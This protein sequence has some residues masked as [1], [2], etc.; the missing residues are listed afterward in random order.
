MYTLYNIYLPQNI[1]FTIDIWDREIKTK[2]KGKTEKHLLLYLLL[3]T[4]FE[5]DNMEESKENKSMAKNVSEN[6]AEENYL[7]NRK[8]T[9]RDAFQDL[10]ASF[11][12]SL[13]FHWFMPDTERS[14]T[15]HSFSKICLKNTNPL[16]YIF[17]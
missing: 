7:P 1:I 16:S 17:L 15:L 3:S 6:E 13:P 9:K 10:N 5:R 14:P 8:H 2:G 4:F 11:N 12:L